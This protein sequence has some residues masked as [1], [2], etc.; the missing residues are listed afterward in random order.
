[1]STHRRSGVEYCLS[2]FQSRERFR[3][4]HPESCLRRVVALRAPLVPLM[5]GIVDQILNLVVTERD[6]LDRNVPERNG[7]SIIGDCNPV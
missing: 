7:K 6:F 1:M 2:F 3:Q 4:V 5:G